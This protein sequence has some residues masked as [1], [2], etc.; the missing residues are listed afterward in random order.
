MDVYILFPDGVWAC[1]EKTKF[2]EEWL[3][4]FNIVAAISVSRFC[5]V[6]KKELL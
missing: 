6:H 3:C 4:V 2:I 5:W 1:M